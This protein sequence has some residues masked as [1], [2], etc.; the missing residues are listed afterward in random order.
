MFGPAPKPRNKGISYYRG[1]PEERLPCGQMDI[2]STTGLAAI[3]GSVIVVLILIVVVLLFL[4]ERKKIT[5][6]TVNNADDDIYPK[7][8]FT[9][10]T[11]ATV[12]DQTFNTTLGKVLVSSSEET[13]NAD[14]KSA[15]T[16]RVVDG[17]A[18]FV[19]TGAAVHFIVNNKTNNP[20]YV[21]GGYIGNELNVSKTGFVR[22]ELI[23]GYVEPTHAL[24]KKS[25]TTIF[26]VNGLSGEAIG[27]VSFRLGLS[28]VKAPDTEV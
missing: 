6:V 25:A 12:A 9:S 11:A 17:P 15:V 3:A 28:V 10:K 26:S 7:I 14:T 16:V 21:H 2:T 5:Q 22:G 23:Y 1:L 8:V 19:A 4:A 27:T 18:S 24:A 13:I 20:I